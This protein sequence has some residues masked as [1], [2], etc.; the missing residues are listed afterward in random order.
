[1]KIKEQ[2]SQFVVIFLLTVDLGCTKNTQSELGS[3][4]Q[5][6]L[7]GFVATVVTALTVTSCG[8]SSDTS[9]GTTIA[10]NTDAIA[11]SPTTDSTKY[12]YALAGTTSSSAIENNRSVSRPFQAST[13]T[14]LRLSQ[15]TTTSGK[16][17]IIIDQCND[18]TW[19]ARSTI[20]VGSDADYTVA[21]RFTRDSNNVAFDTRI[22]AGKALTDAGFVGSLDMHYGDSSTGARLVISASGD[23]DL[24]TLKGTKGTGGTAMAI[25]CVWNATAGCAQFKYGTTEGQ[26]VAF[27]VSVDSATQGKSYAANTDTTL[28]VSLPSAYADVEANPVSSL[29]DHW[30]CGLPSTKSDWDASLS[31]GNSTLEDKGG[32][33]CKQ[34]TG[35]R[36]ESAGDP[37][38]CG[39]EGVNASSVGCFCN[40]LQ[41]V[42][43]YLARF[44]VER[45]MNC[46]ARGIFALIKD[47]TIS[48]VSL[49]DGS[50]LYIKL[51]PTSGG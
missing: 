47:G 40:E 26:A 38:S 43:A 24:N 49:V 20:T 31:L 19:M 3:K 6:G 22:T 50:S 2:L 29:T 35:S 9:T 13:P 33:A 11:S 42:G 25:K 44:M 8:K 45:M 10:N 23:T 30:N 36:W 48:G 34:K 15:A 46:K 27:T 12:D 32:D 18:T 51:T 4:K 16:R 28:C 37:A 7:M 21:T 14:Y 39:T 41:G 5:A 17:E 1:M